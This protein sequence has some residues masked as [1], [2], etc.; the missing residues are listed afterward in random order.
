MGDLTDPFTKWIGVTN[1]VTCPELEHIGTCVN[2]NFGLGNFGTLLAEVQSQVTAMLADSAAGQWQ[3]A[4][5][6]AN[7]A[8]MSSTGLVS[9]IKYA[10]ID[11][12]MLLASGALTKEEIFDLWLERAGELTL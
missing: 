11:A 10:A 2:T 6:H 3:L 4:F 8:I 12:R 9:I 5:V 7:N 1:G